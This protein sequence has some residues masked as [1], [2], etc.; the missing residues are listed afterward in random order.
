MNIELIIK[1]VLAAVA[2]IGLWPIL[3]GIIAGKKIRLREEYRFA[4][5][6]LD[7]LAS[8]RQMHPYALE[9]GCQ[10]IAGTTAIKAIE[11]QYILTLENPA[12]CLRD[13]VL[14]RSYLE[15]LETAGDLKITFSKNTRILGLAGGEKGST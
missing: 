4:K 11:V 14:A 2:V 6:F 12:S 13:F 5:E 3:Y 15:H 10:A 8:G 9:K 7:D 1:V